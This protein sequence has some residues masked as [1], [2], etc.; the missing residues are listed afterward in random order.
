MKNIILSYMKQKNVNFVQGCLKS[1]IIKNGSSPPCK[2]APRII[3]VQAAIYTCYKKNHH[4][5]S[6]V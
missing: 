6:G 5:P 3:S 2:Q 1:I 4:D